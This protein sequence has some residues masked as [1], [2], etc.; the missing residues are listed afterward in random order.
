M[1]SPVH[2]V[3]FRR[4]DDAVAFVAAVSRQCTAPGVARLGDVPIRAEVALF[5]AKT[6]VYLSDAA[7]IVAQRAFGPVPHVP[8]EITEFPADM[9]HMIGVDL[10]AP[11]AVADVL[12]RLIGDRGREQPA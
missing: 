2:E 7:L 1:T 6:C 11:T 5:D 3:T 9:N 8:I 4:L 12:P 10:A